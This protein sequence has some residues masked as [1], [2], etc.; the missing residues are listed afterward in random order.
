MTRHIATTDPD[1]DRIRSKLAHADFDGAARIEREAQRAKGGKKPKVEKRGMNKLESS[2]AAYLD[3]R[4]QCKTIVDWKFEA[5]RLRLAGGA[6]FKPDFLVNIG[7]AYEFHE[8]KGFWR[9]AA[10]VRIKVAAELFPW[11]RFVAVRR[12]KGE[13]ITEEF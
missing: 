4:K 3:E 10:R 8:V 7:C 11:F 13:W 9:E 6:W 2:Y 12:V 1:Y 5:V